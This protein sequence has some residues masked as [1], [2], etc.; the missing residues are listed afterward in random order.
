MEIL[1][2]RKLT[3]MRFLEFWDVFG[4]ICPYL[5]MIRYPN[6]SDLIH[7]RG[8]F[9]VILI[10]ILFSVMKKHPQNFEE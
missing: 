7:R 1:L 10:Y 6:K 8:V 5:G 3:K 4:P 2:P 9:T